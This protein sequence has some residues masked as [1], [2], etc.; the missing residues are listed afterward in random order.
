MRGLGHINSGSVCEIQTEYVSGDGRHGLCQAVC[1]V[2]V[3]L[4]MV[5]VCVCPRFGLCV[6][7]FVWGNLSVSVQWEMRLEVRLASPV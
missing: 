5:C 7:V 4:L 3:A 6:C 1:I 2:S